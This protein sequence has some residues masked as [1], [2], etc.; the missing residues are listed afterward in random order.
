MYYVSITN[1]Y[2]LIDL[3]CALL[4]KLAFLNLSPIF[5]LICNLISKLRLHQ[6]LGTKTTETN[7][8][9]KTDANEAKNAS[10]FKYK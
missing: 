9:L 4:N 8:S 6:F 10:V 2:I 5:L 1:P 3:S 7:K